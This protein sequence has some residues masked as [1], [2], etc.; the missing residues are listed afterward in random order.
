MISVI[1]KKFYFYKEINFHCMKEK[2]YMND[3]YNFSKIL[4]NLIFVN[5]INYSQLAVAIC[6]DIKTVNNYIKGKSILTAVTL[7]KIARYFDVSVDFLV[8]GIQPDRKY[9]VNTLFKF[10]HQ[11]CVGTQLR[12]FFVCLF[13]FKIF[14]VI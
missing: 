7:M 4:N 10:R 14:T 11:S 3:E 12:N 13:T 2:Y 6:V 5:N 1:S 9:S 8:T